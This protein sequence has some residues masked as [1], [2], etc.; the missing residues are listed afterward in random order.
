MSSAPEVTW[1][2][3]FIDLPASAH[4]AGTEFW[5]SVTG[6]AVSPARGEDGEFA[7]LLPDDGDPH[8][9]LQRVGRHET[10]CHLDVH[11][12]PGDIAAAVDRAVA[13]GA[14]EVTRPP[15]DEYVVL[16][17]PAGV[18]HCVVDH[19]QST[20]APSPRWPGGHHAVVDQVCLDVPADRFDAELDYWAALTGW[21]RSPAPLPEFAGL[22][23]PAGIPLRILV[24]ATGSPRAGM[25]LDLAVTDRA[26]ETARHVAL[27]ASVEGTHEGWTVLRAP[28]GEPYCLTDRTPVDAQPGSAS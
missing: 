6:S 7:S 3:A 4:R 25:H 26:A 9:A 14:A 21:V 22:E 18:T 28:S 27:G 17:S 5:R 13:L 19:V 15:G 1:L 24:Q 8:V 20:V 12:A 23:R 2:T 10:T 16:R 11:V